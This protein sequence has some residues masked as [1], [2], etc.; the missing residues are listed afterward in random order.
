MTSNEHYYMRDYDAVAK[1]R[2]H[3]RKVH[4]WSLAVQQTVALKA[5]ERALRRQKPALRLWLVKISSGRLPTSAQVAL[6]ASSRHNPTVFGIE[7]LATR[8]SGGV[9]ESFGGGMDTD[10]IV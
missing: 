3:Q 6:Y 5:Y 9:N 10:S 8:I 1:F 2:E 7:G 4:K